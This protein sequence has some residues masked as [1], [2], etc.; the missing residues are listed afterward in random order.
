MSTAEK[1][2]GWF[3]AE[4]ARQQAQI[5]QDF[6]K[7][8]KVYPGCFDKHGRPIWAVLPPLPDVCDEHR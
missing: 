5:R 2:V 6:R 4:V 7:L 1:P 8:A 3:A